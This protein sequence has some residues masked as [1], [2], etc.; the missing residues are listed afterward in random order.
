M[1][2]CHTLASADGRIVLTVSCNHAM[3]C[4]GRVSV[5]PDQWICDPRG[6][7]YGGQL[8]RSEAA[9][10][11]LTQHL[12]LPSYEPQCPET[13]IPARRYTIAVRDLERLKSLLAGG[14]PV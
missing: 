13:E 8:V 7:R 2:Y 10:A 14:D 5:S 4:H 3:A 6:S 1:T 11:F 9:M 12:G